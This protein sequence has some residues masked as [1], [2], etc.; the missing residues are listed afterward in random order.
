MLIDENTSATLLLLTLSGNHYL[1]HFYTDSLAFNNPYHN[2][3]TSELWNKWISVADKSFFVL[4]WT[5]LGFCCFPCPPWYGFLTEQERCSEQTHYNEV[6]CICQNVSNWTHHITPLFFLE[7]L[8]ICSTRK[9]A[10]RRRQCW[11]FPSCCI[12]VTV[13]GSFC[14]EADQTAAVLEET[15]LSE[16]LFLAYWVIILYKTIF[17]IFCV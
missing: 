12:Q 9:W 8:C 14:G 13:S 15:L 3:N 7:G 4:S 6:N 11:Q 1:D 17:K 2:L 10:Q 16:T 5:L